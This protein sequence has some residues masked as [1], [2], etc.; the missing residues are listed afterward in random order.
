M[1]IL[2]ISMTLFLTACQVGVGYGGPLVVAS[3]PDSQTLSGVNIERSATA[4]NEASIGDPNFSVGE[5]KFNVASA[6]PGGKATIMLASIGTA[7]IKKLQMRSRIGEETHSQD[8]DFEKTNTVT[9]DTEL[10]GSFLYDFILLDVD[11]VAGQVVELTASYGGR[12]VTFGKAKLFNPV[13][14]R[15]YRPKDE[16]CG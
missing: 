10:A 6:T 16:C 11:G 3:T 2:I 7:K 15:R 4:R 14:A 12:T 1:R 8:I 5:L 9:L 13:E